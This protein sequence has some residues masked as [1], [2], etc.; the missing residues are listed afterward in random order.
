MPTTAPRRTR[1]RVNY[2]EVIR[3]Y[4]NSREG[5]IDI[6]DVEA[7]FT[8]SYSTVRNKIKQAMAEDSS[9]RGR[10]AG[11]FPDTSTILDTV[12]MDIGPIQGSNLVTA[13][14]K[15]S[16]LVGG[17]SKSFAE[18]FCKKALGHRYD[19]GSGQVTLTFDELRT[20]LLTPYERYL[21]QS[22]NGLVSIAGTLNQS[23][24]VR[25]L[26]NSGLSDEGA[27]PQFRETGTKS[28][29]DIQIY[30]STERSRR[31]LC[32]EAK[33]YAARERLLRGMADIPPPKVGV[34]FF[35]DA[36]EFG[37]DRVT[38]LA[39]SAQASALYM[40]DSTLA[41]LTEGAKAV[42]F[43]GT[44]RICRSLEQEF[45]PDMKAFMQNGSITHR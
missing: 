17:W 27:N 11:V 39:T 31:T 44:G 32:V 33:S 2:T 4:V 20:E 1:V 42:Q 15:S 24:L 22:G 3:D 35:N 43:P 6:E 37:R 21:V 14:L 16:A 12:E 29:G 7:L 28:E 38:L 10:I 8:V 30:H 36:T 18:H 41:N 26:R 40:P 19:S 25:A 13:N 5:L 9:L 23:L 34:G 45:V